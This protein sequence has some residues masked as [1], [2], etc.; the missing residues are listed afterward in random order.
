LISLGKRLEKIKPSSTL[1]LTAKAKQLKA[2]GKPVVS[3]AGGEPDFP[4]PLES[5]KA[6]SQAMGQGKTK[7]TP[8]SG[9][10]ELKKAVC[11]KYQREGL[12]VDPNQVIISCGAKHSLYNILQVIC[13][14]GDEVIIPQPYWVSYPEMI[15]LA[16][17]VPRMVETSQNGF[18]MTA[19]LLERAITSKTKAVMLNSPSNP[20]G[21]VYSSNEAEAI[22]E[23][24]QRKN[25]FAIN[26]E[27]YEYY[28][29]DDAQ[30]ISVAKFIKDPLKHCCIVNGAS[31]SFA[32]TGLRVG[33]T[34]ADAG[35]VKKMGVLQDHST[36][37]ACSLSQYAALATFGLDQN[38]KMELK[39]NFERKRNLMLTELG[40]IP[41]IKVFKPSGAFYVFASVK[42]TGLTPEKF[43]N[44]LLEEKF[45]ATIP[46]EGF[47]SQEYV[48]F[49]FATTE[50][51]IQDGCKR[52]RE[53]L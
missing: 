34:V 2:E 28:V 37:N 8:S 17:G 33:Y 22:A 24:V 50:T 40:K 4:M 31:K 14:S 44:R 25:L 9:L 16:G 5:Q 47:G 20:T 43:S 52:I 27:I 10:L 41:Q 45:V 11:N 19:P 46:G 32:M 36:S 51:D 38:F 35:L 12:Q 6:L 1:L 29:Y 13:D 30:H 42:G 53:W 26:D 49:S 3:L 39:K 7:Y 21:A 48:R 18:L 15:K 23:L